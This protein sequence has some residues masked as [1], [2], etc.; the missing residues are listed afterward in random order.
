MND[1][2]IC[3][4]EMQLISDNGISKVWRDGDFVVK[5]Q[6]K[7]LTDNEWYALQLLKDTGLVPQAEKINISTI[8]IEYIENESIV[9]P[10]AFHNNCWAALEAL[11][12]HDIR[13]GDLTKYAIRVRDNAPV[14]I[15]WAESRYR[16]DPRP[17]KRR[18]GDA[19]WLD[20][21]IKELC[22]GLHSTSS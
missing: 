6:P 19:Y 21:T 2:V 8:K 11:K 4:N 16:Y 1:K 20:K 15:D 22:N 17:D 10:T 14:I 18:G 13:H 9:D 3:L 12:K 5:E 7:Y